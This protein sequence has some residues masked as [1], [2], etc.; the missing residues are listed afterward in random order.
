[1]SALR[2]R[3]LVRE[4]DSRFLTKGTE[5]A[6][7]VVPNSLHR[8]VLCELRA[9]PDGYGAP[10]REYA[11]RDAHGVTDAQV[12]DGVRPPIVSR[13]PTEAEAL[14]WCAARL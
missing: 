4:R 1:M 10:D 6:N 2:W 8:F 3:T 11:V 12:R 7:A 9:Y 14:A 5:L 13:H